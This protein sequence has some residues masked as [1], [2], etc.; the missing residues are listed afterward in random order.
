MIWVL[1]APL[2]EVGHQ[3]SSLLG[4]V[5]VNVEARDAMLYDLSW[6]SMERR[7]SR[8]STGHGLNDGETERFIEGRL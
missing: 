3:I 1:L 4:V 6:P 7:E 5:R 8:K 2:E